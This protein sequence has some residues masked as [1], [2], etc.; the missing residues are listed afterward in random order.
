MA[1]HL[2]VDEKI[3]LRYRR[4]AIDSSGPSR[5]PYVGARG[6][7]FGGVG[8]NRLRG[9]AIRALPSE[10]PA[11][12]YAG[13]ESGDHRYRAENTEVK[14]RAGSQGHNSRSQVSMARLL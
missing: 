11:D 14:D 10:P 4:I 2:H 3:H 7:G 13:N 1:F 12:E 8:S 9:N 5:Y 6:N